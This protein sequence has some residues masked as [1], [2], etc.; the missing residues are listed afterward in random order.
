M[1]LFLKKQELAVFRPKNRFNLFDLK[2]F[3]M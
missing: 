1:L 2:A 3:S